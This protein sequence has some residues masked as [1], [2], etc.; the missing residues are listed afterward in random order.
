MINKVTTVDNWLKLAKN[1]LK[2]AQISSYSLDSELI[3]CN[4]LKVDRT[5]ILAYPKRKLTKQNIFHANH[6]LKRRLQHEPLA[7]I[8]G[9]KEFYGRN[10]KVNSSVLVPRPETEEIIEQL[11]NN[12]VNNNEALLDI[13]T[14]SGILAV[15]IAKEFQNKN[16]KAYASDISKDALAVAKENAA[17]HNA[18]ISF[19]NSNLLENIEQ[20]ILNEVTILVANL[21]YVNKNWIN[22]KK[23]NELHY[24]PQIALYSEK[25]GLELIEKLLNTTNK[26]PNLKYL[27]LE[28]DP[29]QFCKI[30]K[31]AQENNLKKMVQKNYTIVFKKITLL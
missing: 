21:P 2:E 16:I 12:L 22:Q 29:E 7:Y 6:F 26:I 9:F 27:I 1:K 14:G 24:E 13:G 30:E 4:I 10:F 28:A 8:L 25:E 15:T 20:N 3:L 17:I 31:I 5:T 23:P 18:N 11:K 19:I